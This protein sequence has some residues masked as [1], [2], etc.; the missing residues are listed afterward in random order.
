MKIIPAC[1]VCEMS[2]QIRDRIEQR[3]FKNIKQGVRRNKN[4]EI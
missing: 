4:S 2:E 1:Y 3:K